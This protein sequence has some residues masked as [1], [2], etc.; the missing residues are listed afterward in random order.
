MYAHMHKFYD[1]TICGRSRQLP[2][3]CVKCST[4]QLVNPGIII[5]KLCEV[6]QELA[7]LCSC[8]CCGQHGGQLQLCLPGS[9]AEVREVELLLA[10]ATAESTELCFCT[11]ASACALVRIPIQHVCLL[12]MLYHI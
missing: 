7:S 3:L 12:R 9:P 5:T 8:C 10:A 2:V 6:Q 11:V 1:S 4:P